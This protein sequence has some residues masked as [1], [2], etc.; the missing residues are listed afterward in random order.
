MSRAGSANL[1]VDRGGDDGAADG[2]SGA[3]GGGQESP[4]LASH[5]YIQALPHGNSL[6]ATWSHGKEKKHR[7]GTLLLPEE[8]R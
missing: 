3:A 6:C 2:G 8:A 4:Y 7:E 1:L 5:G